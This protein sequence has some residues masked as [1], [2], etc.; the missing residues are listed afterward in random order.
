MRLFHQTY[1]DRNGQQRQSRK[2]YVE[3]R[4]D[5]RTRRLSLFTDR[6]ASEEA[7]RRI[8]QLIALRVVRGVPD[9]GLT[10]FIETLPASIRIKLVEFNLLD[11]HRVAVTKPIDEHLSDFE[12]H[13]LCRGNTA[14]HARQT[15]SRAR[16]LLE[17]CKARFWSDVTSSR[18]QQAL[19]D[20]HRGGSD[21][22]PVLAKTVNYYLASLKAFAKW[23]VQDGRATESP[24]AHMRPLRETA[25][26]KR[27]RRALSVEEVRW[28]LTSTEASE[29]AC[30]VSG[31]DRAL[32]Y[33]LALETGLRANEL[34]SLTRA[35]FDLS[36]QDPS[37]TV[38][39]GYSKRRRRDVQPL[40]AETADFLRQV[41]ATK[42]P[43][44][45]ALAMPHK[46][47]M[48]RM[49]REDLDR[50]REAWLNA[51]GSPAIR[52]ERERT[53]FLASVDHQ[54]RI[55]DFHALRHTFIT[56]LASSGVHP[57][58]AQA[59]ARHSTI[60]LT[61]DRYTHSFRE[62]E[63]DA[64]EAMPALDGPTQESAR[65]TGTDAR[66]ATPDL[67]GRS[68]G[69]F[70]ADSHQPSSDDNGQTSGA[71]AAISAHKNRGVAA[72]SAGLSGNPPPEEAKGAVGFEPTND[73]FAIRSLGPLGYAPDSGIQ[74]A[75]GR[76]LWHGEGRLASFKHRGRPLAPRHDPNRVTPASRR[77]PAATGPAR[78]AASRRRCGPS[79]LARGG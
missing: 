35:S 18:V 5:E 49:L 47:H 46:N 16:R 40:R 45:S 3:F 34:R 66:L 60:S 52:A 51:A 1:R 7:A 32:L 43:A 77:I 13:L 12:S 65:A 73:G 31:P 30:G 78:L 2:W 53:D 75:G 62:A 19:H 54:G 63:Q 50:A 57:K 59:L 11:A 55:V 21:K 37:V 22:A 39:A 36:D 29:D 58:T 74:N 10:R 4:H 38:A 26:V 68:A 9:A 6:K 14:A 69:R 15:T 48:A 67:S 8:E 44:A 79:C 25:E 72:E 76:V 20:L 42:A 17:A 70:S 41:L 64:I 27:E 33:R 56:M 24:V 23:M 71:T 28:L 61:M